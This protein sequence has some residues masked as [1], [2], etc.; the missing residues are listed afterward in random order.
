MESRKFIA[1]TMREYLNEQREIFDLLYHGTDMKSGLDIQKKGV[2]I[3]KGHGGYFGWGFYTTPTIELAKSNYADFSG[4]EN[5]G[6]VLEL[7]LSKNAKILDLRDPDDFEIWKPYS[8]KIYDKNLYRELI[9]AGIDGL[10]DDSFEG[11]VIYNTNVIFL[12]Q[13]I[14]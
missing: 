14:K 8:N 3:L 12:R 4:D 9:G 7:Q 1:T 13:I 5:G 2:D 11:V 6:V 10:W